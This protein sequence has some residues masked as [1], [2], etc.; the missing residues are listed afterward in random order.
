ME[1]SSP[2]PSGGPSPIMLDILYLFA[3][4]ALFGALG[5]VVRAVEKL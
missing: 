1:M 3:T 4:L 2:Y 5:L